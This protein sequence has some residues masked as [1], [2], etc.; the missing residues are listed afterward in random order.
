MNQAKQL[1][2][3]NGVLRME[4]QVALDT[5][6]LASCALHQT[7]PSDKRLY[8]MDFKT[9]FKFSTFHN[10]EAI[11][12]LALENAGRL[13][14]LDEQL[15]K[16]WKLRK[17]RA[18]RKNVLLD[19]EREAILDFMETHGIYYMPLK[20]VILRHIYPQ[21]G[22]RQM[23]DNDILYDACHDEEL[24]RFMLERG[25]QA[26][27]YRVSYHD[28]YLK[29]P[30]YNFE[31]HRSLVG[32]HH[33]EKWQRYYAD[34]KDRLVL[35]QGKKYG[36]HF[37]DEDFYIFMT[38]HFYKHYSYRGAGLRMMLDSYVYEW[39]MEKLDWG[40]IE[41]ELDGLGAGNF[42]RTCRALAKKLLSDP[43]KSEKTSL[44]PEEVSMLDILITSGAYGNREAVMHKQIEQA[45]G[46]N[47][48]ELGWKAKLRFVY[49][50][51]FPE[52]EWFRE[53]CLFC[54]NHV[55]AIPFYNL[56][57]WVRGLL[58]R[59]KKLFRELRMANKRFS[60]K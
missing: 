23:T 29:K 17:E 12:F 32:E 1:D 43:E 40:Y 16:E 26:E 4:Q 34:V 15:K 57:R 20:G 60:E 58:F 6:Y 47:R 33:D 2:S 10:M 8:A 21:A 25:Y 39:R 24:Y 52:R 9:V 56:Y 42:D 41:S 38:I 28:V 59:R 31:M 3:L 55:W 35:D 5:L 30:I 18:F 53:R 44:T 11:C 27:K 50:R 19:I 48:N 7:A 22:M 13:D 36:Y 45:T 46:K 14:V 54:Y 49:R 37:S 51:L